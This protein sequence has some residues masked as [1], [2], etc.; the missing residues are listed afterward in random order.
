MKGLS[1]YSEKTHCTKY[2]YQLLFTNEFCISTSFVSLHYT[3]YNPPAAQNI[4]WLCSFSLIMAADIS[5]PRTERLKETTV[6]HTRN[7]ITCQKILLFAVPDIFSNEY[8]FQLLFCRQQWNTPHIPF[9]IY[10]IRGLTLLKSTG[11]TL[12][13][14]ATQKCMHYSVEFPKFGHKYNTRI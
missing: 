9:S 1:I 5:S 8:L 4:H 3:T 2:S 6:C 10:T 7:C 13:I 14:S 11:T 12:W